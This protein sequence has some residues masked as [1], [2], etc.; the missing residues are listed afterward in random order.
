MRFVRDIRIGLV[1]AWHRNRIVIA[2]GAVCVVLGVIVGLLV[3]A[4]LS[5]TRFEQELHT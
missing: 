1:E 3:H 4:R 5:A 2:V